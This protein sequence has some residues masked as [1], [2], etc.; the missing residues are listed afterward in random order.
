MISVFA[1]DL[2]GGVLHTFPGCRKLWQQSQWYPATKMGL[3]EPA[4]PSAWLTLGK[5]LGAS[6]G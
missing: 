2:A 1:D 4:L 5:F 3:A 6:L